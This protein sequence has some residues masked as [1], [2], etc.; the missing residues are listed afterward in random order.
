M[1][2]ILEEA[3]SWQSR[4]V[5]EIARKKSYRFHFLD[6]EDGCNEYWCVRVCSK[7]EREKD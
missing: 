5:M 2:I 4:G 3:K 1:G 7:G 6:N